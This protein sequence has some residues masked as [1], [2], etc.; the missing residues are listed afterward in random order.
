MLVQART[1][2]KWILALFRTRRKR[3]WLYEKIKITLDFSHKIRFPHSHEQKT[4]SDYC[5]QPAEMHSCSF[6]D[7][8]LCSARSHT[9]TRIVSPKGWRDEICQKRLSVTNAN[10]RDW[11]KHSVGCC[12]FLFCASCQNWLMILDIP[13]ESLLTL[14]HVANKNIWNPR[15]AQPVCWKTLW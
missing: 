7:C 9:K 2:G 6:M 4:S 11:N 5:L 13:R 14:S 15:G 3:F 1:C 10:F 8:F 12:G